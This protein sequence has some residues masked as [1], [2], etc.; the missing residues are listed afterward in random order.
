MH[1]ASQL[2][3]SITLHASGGPT[4]KDGVESSLGSKKLI[5]NFNYFF[6][7]YEIVCSL[8]NLHGTSMV[9]I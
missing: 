2:L 5:L 6:G 1:V 3:W 7:K 4:C 8:K 9:S